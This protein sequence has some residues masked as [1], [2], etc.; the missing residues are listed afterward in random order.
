MERI[1]KELS[2]PGQGGSTRDVSVIFEGSTRQGGGHCSNRSFY[3]RR[4]GD[5]AA[6][7]KDRRLLEVEF[8]NV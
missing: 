6:F 5:N 3:C 1:K 8:I 4:M 2:L 7:N